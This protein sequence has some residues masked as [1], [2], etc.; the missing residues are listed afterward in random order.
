MKFKPEEQ[1]KTLWYITWLVIFALGLVLW[2]VLIFLV[3][4]LIFVIC[5]GIWFI[6]M[7][8][9]LFWIPRAYQALEYSIEEDSVKMKEGVF[10]KKHVTVPYLKITNVDVTQGPIQR[11]LGIGVIHVQTAGAG[12]QQ[13]QKS[14]LKINGVKNPDEL[15]D[16]IFKNIKTYHLNRSRD[17]EKPVTSA[18]GKA[19]TVVTMDQDSVD[20]NSNLLQAILKELSAIRKKLGNSNVS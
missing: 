17:L 9:V 13:G 14:E 16:Q 7:I 2:V 6:I 3:D 4:P 1:L 12:G 10:W 11:A 8:P 5:L 20:L 19:G 18:D 15:R